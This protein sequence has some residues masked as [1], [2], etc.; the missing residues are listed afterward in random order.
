[1]VTFIGI[2]KLLVIIK[3][4]GYTVK[5]KLNVIFLIFL[6]LADQFVHCNPMHCTDEIGESG[7]NLGIGAGG[8]GA[9]AVLYNVGV[10][11]P[12]SPQ[13][14]CHTNLL[15]GDEEGDGSAA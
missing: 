7:H 9:Q 11:C 1:M 3:N 15:G 2:T 13:C 5:I 12:G 14:L 6:C 8:P 10:G 4:V